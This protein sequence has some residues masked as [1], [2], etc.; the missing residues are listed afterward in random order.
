[1]ETYKILWKPKENL[2][3]LWTNNG[4]IGAVSGLTWAVAIPTG[5]QKHMKS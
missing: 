1:M 3:N 4:L 2:G 5:V